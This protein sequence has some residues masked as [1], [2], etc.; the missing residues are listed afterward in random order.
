[1]PFQIPDPYAMNLSSVAL[2][3]HV[4]NALYILGIAF[5]DNL[6]LRVT[7]T[8]AGVLEFYYGMFL[9]EEPLIEIMFW[10][11]LWVV[12][13]GYHSALIIRERLGIRFTP[14]ELLVK[15]LAFG[16]MPDSQFKRFI[17]NAAWHDYTAGTR[18]ITRDTKIDHLMLLTDGTAKVE[19]DGRVIATLKRAN[20]VGE[21]SYVTGST[22]NA[23]VDA[24]T[25]L[26]L[27]AWDREDL[28][29]LAALDESFA[30]AIH[31]AFNWDLIHKIGRENA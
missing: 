13:N 26:R 28:K 5:K 21:M 11:G 20:F 31:S 6:K 18:I 16:F 17:E 14:D 10:S 27:V 29:R 3:M 30:V 25:D 23:D 15:Q 4:A 1:M 2:L 9:A 12:I 22:T 24:L 8:A 7:L 19:A